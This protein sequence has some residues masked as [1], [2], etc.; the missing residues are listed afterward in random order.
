VVVKQGCDRVEYAWRDFVD[1]IEYEQGLLTTG[2]GG[3]DSV[4]ELDL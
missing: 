2:D 4:S 3:F 1:L